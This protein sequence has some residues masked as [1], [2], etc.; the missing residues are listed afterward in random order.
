SLELRCANLFIS[1]SE[2][3]KPEKPLTRIMRYYS[4]PSLDFQDGI[5][6]TVGLLPRRSIVSW[7]HTNQA[8]LVFP[9]KEINQ[10]KII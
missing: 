10:V 8:L 9:F 2:F 1:R 5:S 6:L 4:N 7:Q 3:S